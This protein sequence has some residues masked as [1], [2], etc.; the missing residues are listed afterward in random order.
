MALNAFMKI[1]NAGGEARQGKYGREGWIEIQGWEWEIQAET[2]WTKG[3]GASVGKPNPGAMSFEHYYDRASPVIL[4]YICTGKSFDEVKLEMCKTTGSGE[5]E[6][7]FVV[8]M[9]DAFLT[10]VNCSADNEGNVVQKCEIVFKQ[11]SIDYKPQ[12]MPAAPGMKVASPGKLGAPIN[13]KWNIP[14][15]TASGGA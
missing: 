3:G 2:S 10:K 7:F 8:T 15:G 12:G 9:T 11:I 1:G 6:A 13:Y 14:A 5:P 4:A